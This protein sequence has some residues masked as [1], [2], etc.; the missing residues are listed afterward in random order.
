MYSLWAGLCVC[1]VVTVCFLFFLITII[2]IIPRN[3]AGNR[4]SRFLGRRLAVVATGAPFFL[5]HETASQKREN[6][7]KISRLPPH[8]LGESC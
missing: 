2:I 1:L 3:V 7:R 6:L 8:R 4:R 5:F